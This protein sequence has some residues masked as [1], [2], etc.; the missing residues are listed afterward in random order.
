MSTTDTLLGVSNLGTFVGGTPQ[1]FEGDA[2]AGHVNGFVCSL[3]LNPIV[4]TFG[5]D[6][7]L[8]GNADGDTGW[9]LI[10]DYE[11]GTGGV[12][13]GAQVG[14]GTTS[15]TATSETQFGVSGGKWVLLTLVYRP[16]PSSGDSLQLWANGSLIASAN[17]SAYAPS[18]AALRLGGDPQVQLVYGGLGYLADIGSNYNSA[19]SIP[20][21]SSAVIQTR[22]MVLGTTFD[23]FPGAP[24]L[25]EF[26]NAWDGAS[27]L[28]GGP[29]SYVAA[30]SGAAFRPG[31]QGPWQPRSGTVALNPVNLEG[32]TV[33]PFVATYWHP[34]AGLNNV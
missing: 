23:S 18:A 33:N 1:Y 17:P 21:H 5:S 14:T 10:Y 22:R 29:V 28:K 30:N 7:E 4:M 13:F 19:L 15:I 3:L 27:L 2:A 26:D 16:S 20:L 25:I 8:A 34:N 9:R 32:A 24:T 12:T 31:I 6:R 11:D